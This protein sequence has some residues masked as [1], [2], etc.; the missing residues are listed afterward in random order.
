[1]ERAL[2]LDDLRK[3]R[4]VCELAG[5]IRGYEGVKEASVERVKERVEG[6]LAEKLVGVGI[7]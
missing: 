1:V 4:E 7:K 6:L 5:E 2:E 3:A